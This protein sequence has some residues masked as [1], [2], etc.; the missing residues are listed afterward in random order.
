MKN[1]AFNHLNSV[2]LKDGSFSGGASELYKTKEDNRYM[3]RF[4]VK[5]SSRNDPSFLARIEVMTKQIKENLFADVPY[6]FVVTDEK[7][8]TVKAWEY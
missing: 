2:I 7:M 5:E 6:S 4:P 3:I 1:K 8:N